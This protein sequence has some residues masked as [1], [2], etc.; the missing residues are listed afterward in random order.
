MVRLLKR[1]ILD[2]RIT[3]FILAMVILSGLY[4]YHQ[5]PRQ[6]TPDVSAPVAIVTCTYPGASPATWNGW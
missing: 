4:G 6:E 1:V 2:A 5:M 3:L